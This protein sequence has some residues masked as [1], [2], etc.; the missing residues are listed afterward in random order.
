[1]KSSRGWTLVIAIELVAL[2]LCLALVGVVVGVLALNGSQVAFAPLP[3]AAPVF[4]PTSV[5]TWTPP[6]TQAPAPTNTRVVRTLLP[7]ATRAP[8]V[9]ASRTPTRAASSY[10]IIVPTPTAPRMAYPITFES[11]LKVITYAVPGQTTSELVKSL[12]TLAIPDPNE[13][14]GRYNARTDWY[15]SAHWFYRPTA[16]GCEVERGTVSVAM[17]M[18]LPIISSTEGVSPDVLNHWTNFINNTIGHESGH[19]KISLQGARDY[20]RDLGNFP[21]APDCNAIQPRL[22]DL[23]DR[24]SDAVRRDNIDY[25]ASTQHGF[26]QGAVFP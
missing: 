7:S 4:A 8:L 13:A 26:K 18:T 19:V 9:I 14:N 10:D 23:F 5:P 15:L 24:A 20:Q 12:N 21:P 1:M 25:D 11:N 17:T 22:H 3:T 16:R 6:A 2:C